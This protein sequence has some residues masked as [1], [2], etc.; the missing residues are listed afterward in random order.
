MCL[1]HILNKFHLDFISE[2]LNLCI[3][4]QS[5]IDSTSVFY[6]NWWYLSD[7]FSDILVK[8]FHQTSVFCF[9]IF[10]SFENISLKNI[11]IG[12]MILTW[13]PCILF[14]DWCS[15]GNIMH[16]CKR[17]PNHHLVDNPES[18][19][20]N[21]PQIS[22][23]LLLYLRS[24]RWGKDFGWETSFSSWFLS[25]SKLSKFTWKI[26]MRAGSG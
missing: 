18:I 26:F 22:Q 20:H 8:G 19:C 3:W 4:V 5:T 2:P 13:P 16:Q 12:S 15:D 21:W 23:S 10:S 1:S 24:L 6:F 14:R 9:L 7:L 17:F 25:P 11:F